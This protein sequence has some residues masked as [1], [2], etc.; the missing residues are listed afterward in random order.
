MEL[1]R[2]QIIKALECC[3]TP[4][5]TKCKN[6]PREREDALCMYRLSNDALALIKE[7]AEENERLRGIPEQLYKEMSE[8]MV[9]ERKIAR[10]LAVRKMQERLKER[11]VSYGNISFRVVPVD[12]I[13]Q[14]AKE[15]LEGEG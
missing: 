1:N 3:G 11:K 4:K 12:D 14:I 13:D 5:W 10:K 7:L 6:C 9:E 15:M 8:R 2:D